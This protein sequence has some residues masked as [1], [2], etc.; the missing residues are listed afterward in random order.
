MGKIKPNWAGHILGYHFGLN[1]FGDLPEGVEWLYPY[2]DAETRRCMEAFYTRFYADIGPRVMIL[3]INPGRFGAGVTGVPFTDP[4]RLE[5][6]CSILNAFHKR[7]ELSSVFVYDI[8]NVLGGPEEF[9]RLFYITS[10]CPLG[11]IKDGKN[12]N[13]Y[14]S[15]ALAER[16]RPLIVDNLK[17][18]CAFGAR[19]DVVF[20][21]GQGTNFKYLQKWNGQLGI[22]EK[23]VPLPHPRWV[24][25]YRRKRKDEFLANYVSALTKV[26]D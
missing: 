1:P 10:V 7:Q 2:D 24:M 14:D 12:F 16:V 18:Q 6:E 22:F 4:V 19:T 26:L 13:Y 25:Q 11:F 9:Y 21:M 15:P 23:V 8:I 17:Q 3:G 20:C 5:S